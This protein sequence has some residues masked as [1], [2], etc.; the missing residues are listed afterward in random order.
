MLRTSQI[1]GATTMNNLLRQPLMHFLILG[2]L[3]FAIDYAVNGDPDDPRQIVIDDEQYAEIAG[4][5]EDN[6]GEAPSD[7]EMADLTIKW[8]QN[9][10]LYREARLMGLD[11]GDDM[12]RSRLILKMRNVV[13]GQISVNAPN[14]NDLRAWFEDNRVRYD[15]P[16]TYDFEQFKLRDGFTETEAAQLAEQL[17]GNLPSAEL[18][19]KI[20]HYKRRPIGNLE[21]VFGKAG[22]ADLLENKENHHWRAVESPAGWHLARITG[23]YAGQPADFEK[24]RTR[25]GQEWRK[26]ASDAQVAELLRDIASR[27]RITIEL[28]NP[29]EN[30]DNKR[31]DTDRLAMGSE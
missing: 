7:E 26:Q 16:P 11:K 2:L 4:I 1:C 13:F 19:Q 17:Q 8:A 25:I 12:I 10:V 30:V 21:Y 5:Y 20:R 22:A 29:P 24:L 3:V 31:I 27:Y 9:E 28:S 23:E 15:I 14:E 18:Q 6:Q